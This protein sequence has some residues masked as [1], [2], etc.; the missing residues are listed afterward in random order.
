MYSEISSKTFSSFVQKTVTQ[1]GPNLMT[2][3]YQ[4]EYMSI[5]ITFRIIFRSLFKGNSDRIKNYSMVPSIN[6]R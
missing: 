1:S 6:C 2:S 4:S 5:K 3:Q